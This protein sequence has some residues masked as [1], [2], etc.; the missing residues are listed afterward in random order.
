ME[1]YA[2]AQ[3]SIAVAPPPPVPVLEVLLPPVPLVLEVLDPPSPVPPL[4]SQAGIAS[5]AEM[6]A[7]P[8]TPR[9]RKALMA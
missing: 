4:S 5:A 1:V 3:V 7:N 6:A 9:Y 2:S 8:I